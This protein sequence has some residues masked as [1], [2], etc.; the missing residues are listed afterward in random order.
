MPAPNASPK[1]IRVAVV[2]DVPS[3]CQQLARALRDAGYSV[4]P[5]SLTSGSAPD[6]VRELR[7]AVVLLRTG[8]RHLAAARALAH[9]THNGGPALVLLSPPASGKCLELAL[10]GG[11]FV[12]LIEPVPVQALSAAVRLAAARSRDAGHLET[13]L[14]DLREALEARK[15]VERAKSILMRRLGL[16]EE[17]AHRRLQRESR[18]RNRKLVDTAW[19][20]IR[21]EAQLWP[22]PRRPVRP[23]AA[24]PSGPAPDGA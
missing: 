10:D 13:R 14:R 20:V 8:Q 9:I 4:Q 1:P 16:G 18:N 6:R 21:A 23:I 12:H 24:A 15:V 2:A 17:E 5:F 11:A 19:H 3:V 22:R 7:P